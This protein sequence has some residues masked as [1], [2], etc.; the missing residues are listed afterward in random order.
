VRLSRRLVPGLPS[1]GLDTL[2]RWFGFDNPARHR[3]GGDAL[4]T[5]RL[6]SRLLG[7]AR[8]AG[9]LTLADLAALEARRG[10]AARRKRSALPSEP[11]ADSW[12]GYDA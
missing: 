4:V 9:A 2:T 3:A 7:F 6:L 10:R 5:A 11:R 12:A 8:E 1:C